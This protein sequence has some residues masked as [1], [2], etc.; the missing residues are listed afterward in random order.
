MTL[1]PTFSDILAK[2]TRPLVGLWNSTGSPVAMEILAAAGTDVVII[3]GEHGPVE[4]SQILTLLQVS[5]AYPVTPLVRVPWNDEVRIKQVLDLGAQ[6]LIVPMVSSVYEA[7]AVVAATRYPAGEGQ[8]P[9]RRGMGAMIARAARWGL[10]ED[11]VANAD[12][13]VSVTVQIETTQG[14]RAAADIASVDGVDAVFVGPADLSADM[15]YY[16][17]SGN[18]RVTDAVDEIIRA[19]VAAGTPVGVNAFDPDAAAHFIEAGASFVV[20]SADVHFIAFGA[21]AAIDRIV[22]SQ[23]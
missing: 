20:T 16:T 15:G 10:V 14:V 11:Y 5:E 23:K 18:Q 21:R 4:L 2:A 3:D 19:C 22:D 1:K 7:H 17:D 8:R 12:S 9:G 6:N 13:S